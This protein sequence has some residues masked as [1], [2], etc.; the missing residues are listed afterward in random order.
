LVDMKK[1][2]I[3]KEELSDILDKRRRDLVRVKRGEYS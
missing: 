2:D 3:V 1:W